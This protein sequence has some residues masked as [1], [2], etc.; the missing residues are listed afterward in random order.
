MLNWVSICTDRLI[1]EVAE[2][3]ISRRKWALWISVES[4]TFDQRFYSD[5][6]DTLDEVHIG[7]VPQ[8]HNNIFHILA[9]TRLKKSH[10]VKQLTA[11]LSCILT[12]IEIIEVTTIPLS[13]KWWKRSTALKHPC[14]PIIT[15]S[16]SRTRVV[17]VSE[18]WVLPLCGVFHKIRSYLSVKG[19]INITINN[20]DILFLRAILSHISQN[21]YNFYLQTV[22]HHAIGEPSHH[23]FW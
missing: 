6:I 15:A 13:L 17:Y 8:R 23:P 2:F 11:S 22:C 18:N 21:M 12:N 19:L 5:F 20:V 16:L 7:N 1:Y 4:A 3:S 9:V 14:V 10:N